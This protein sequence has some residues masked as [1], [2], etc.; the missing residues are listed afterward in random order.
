[1][2][3]NLDGQHALVT[4]GG[5][6]VGSA[7]AVALAEAGAAVTITGRREAPLRETAAGHDKMSFAIADVTDADALRTAFSSAADKHGPVSIVIANAGVAESQPFSR[8]TG[9]QWQHTIDVNLTGVFNTFQ[10]GLAP[11]LA[12][13]YGRMIAIASVAGLRGSAYVSSYCAA[14]HGVVG[15]TRALAAELGPKGV[16]V[17]AICPGYTRTPMLDRTLDNIVEK[18][19]MSREQAAASLLKGS[20]TGQFVQPD[21]IADMV[22]QLCADNAA[23]RN[24]EAIAMP[25]GIAG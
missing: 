6:G 20:P 5:T 4:G 21:E 13:G 19:G 15:L 22:L 12:A 24:G 18:T 3:A 14:K 11:M 2:Q 1:M 7:I 17:N 8:L 25:E 10:C 16:T 9:E 23:P